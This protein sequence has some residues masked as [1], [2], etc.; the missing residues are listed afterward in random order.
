[1]QSESAES[2]SGKPPDVQTKTASLL[3]KIKNRSIVGSDV[4]N[5]AFGCRRPFAVISRDQLPRDQFSL[6][7]LSRDQLYCTTRSTQIFLIQ[8]G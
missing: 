8:S 3:A 2:S 1:M 5:K 4:I 6:N 7:Q